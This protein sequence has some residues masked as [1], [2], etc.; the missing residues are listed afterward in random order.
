[1]TSRDTYSQLMDLLAGARYRVMDH[2]PEGR[3]DAASA[4]RGHRLEQAAKCMV[5]GIKS[6]RGTRYVLAVIPGHRRVDF[7][8]LRRLLDGRDAVLAPP[9]DAERLAG[10]VSGSI[11]PFSF[12]HE[13]ELVVDPDLLEQPELFF[14]AARL[15][16]SIAL[17]TEDYVTLAQ[18]FVKERISRPA[19]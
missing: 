19:A 10:C 9:A 16:R 4:I 12:H 3:T 11:I 18:P 2:E 8:R 14:N 7:K 6:D 1:M 13:L 15:D 17:T 5:V